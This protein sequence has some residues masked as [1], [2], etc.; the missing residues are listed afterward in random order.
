MAELRGNNLA[1]SI[2]DEDCSSIQ[3]LAADLGLGAQRTRQLIDKAIKARKLQNL[4]K[5]RGAKIL[6]APQMV[7]AIKRLYADGAIVKPRRKQGVSKSAINRAEIV[8]QVP[9]FDKEVAQILLGKFGGQDKIADYLRGK[10][11]EA[12]KPDLK[13]LKDLEAEFEKRKKSILQRL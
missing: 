2:P 12:Y 3:E 11:D 9:I 1:E 10:L 4:S 7:E 6:Y 8:I 13:A 5:K